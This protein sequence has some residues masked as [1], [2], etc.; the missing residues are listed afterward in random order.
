MP[1]YTTVMLGVLD[2][3]SSSSND[4]QLCHNPRVTFDR[5]QREHGV[6]K[7]G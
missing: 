7:G 4:R 2:H 5:F 6:V 3:S 1:D